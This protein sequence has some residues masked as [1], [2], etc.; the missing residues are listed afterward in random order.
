MGV[1]EELEQENICIVMLGEE[2]GMQNLPS[3]VI[4]SKKL[5]YFYK[6]T[7]GWGKRGF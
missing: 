7:L 1:Y 2:T 5:V 3:S 6:Y 4:K